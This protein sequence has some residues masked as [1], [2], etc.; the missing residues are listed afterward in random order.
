MNLKDLISEFQYCH[1]DKKHP[2]IFNFIY[3]IYQDGLTGG[4]DYE[5]FKDSFLSFIADAEDDEFHEF[6][7]ESF[8]DIKNT[9]E[10]SKQKFKTLW[11]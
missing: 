8:F 2:F 1:Y 6:F 11:K 9:G 3:S 10:V 7:F 5:Q 4:L